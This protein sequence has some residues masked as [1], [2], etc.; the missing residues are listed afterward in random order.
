MTNRLHFD[1]AGTSVLVTGGTSGIGH[2]IASAF[3]RAGA[4][5]TVTGTRPAPRDYERDLSAFAYRPLEVRDHDAVDE[6]AGRHRPAG[7]ARQQRRRQ[8]SRRA[9]TSGTPTASPPPSTSTWRGPCA[10]PCACAPALGASTMAG[11]ASVVNLVSMTAF[12][13]TT[14][15]PGYAAAKAALLTL[16]RNLAAHWAGDGIRVN[17]VAP[18]LIDTPMTAP[19]KAFPATPRGRAGPC[20]HAAHGYA[21]GGGGRRPVPVER[22]R[23][24]HHRQHARR[25]RRLP[26]PL[27]RGA[28]VGDVIEIDDLGAPVLNDVQRM[29]HRL[30]GVEDHRAHGRRRLRRR[31][32]AD[33]ARR[34]R[35][36]RTSPSGSGCSWGRWTPTRSGPG[37]GRLMMFG[38]CV[39]SAANRLLVHDLLRRHPEIL[40]VP[41]ARPVIVVGLPRS[42]TTHLVNL[43]AADTPVPLHAAVGVLRAGARTRTSPRGDRRGGSPLDP[44]STARGRPCRRRRRWWR[45]CTRWSPTTSTRRSSCSCPTSRAT[46]S[47]GWPGRRGGATTTS[48]TTRHRTTPT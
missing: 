19:M 44:L 4:D 6:L 18:G 42:G 12:R 29:A 9:A 25:R 41:I 13:S 30:R 21:R 3:A 23:R 20:H 37:I 24:L 7:R 31:P 36:R 35:G 1:F 38:D 22:V 11:G 15:V 27:G 14:I 32:G 39:R 5:V 8:L 2:A 26:R 43:L 47:S 17:A 46:P 48:P 45:P 28:G 40:D 34:L 16:T 33:R 10:S